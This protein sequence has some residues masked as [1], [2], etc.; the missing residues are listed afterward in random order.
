MVDMFLIV[1]IGVVV[2]FVLVHFLNFYK[3]W[4]KGWHLIP[5]CEWVCEFCNSRYA[6][7][8]KNA[9]HKKVLSAIFGLYVVGLL[10]VL[11]LLCSTMF[12][13]PFFFFSQLQMFAWT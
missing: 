4:C 2:V 12:M 9:G 6:C 11:G 13:L 10:G 3:V 1:L 5:K 8:A 7:A